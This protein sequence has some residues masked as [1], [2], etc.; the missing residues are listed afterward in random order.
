MHACTECQLSGCLT[1]YGWGYMSDWSE[2]QRHSDSDS[3]SAI[4]R[5]QSCTHANESAVY[6]GLKAK[7]RSPTS[8]SVTVCAAGHTIRVFSEDGWPAHWVSAGLPGDLQCCS[9]NGL[10]L[11][12]SVT[13][14]VL[15]FACPC[16]PATRF[17]KADSQ[18]FQISAAV[19][20]YNA[21]GC[22]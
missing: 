16:A 22:Y 19:L 15:W 20:E 13:A 2:E 21:Y 12:D 4:R 10:A 5:V 9:G 1:H 8:V 14:V 11:L 3:A 7:S 18:C 17:E 6:V